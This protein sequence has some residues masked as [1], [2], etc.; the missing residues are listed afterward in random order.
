MMWLALRA[1]SAR[2]WRTELMEKAGPVK[3]WTLWALAAL[4]AA[5]ILLEL[6]QHRPWHIAILGV[7]LIHLAI[8]AVMYWRQSRQSEDRPMISLVLL[9]AEPRYLDERALGKLVEKA[10]GVAMDDSRDALHFVAGHSPA[11]M[12]R[13]NGRTFMVNNLN[14]PYFDEPQKAAE[15]MRELRLR[16]IVAEHMAWLSVHL[17]ASDNNDSPAQS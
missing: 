11:L 6:F 9:L 10:W 14:V 4:V 17:L 5:L 12:I 8:V 15:E 16:K 3:L 7:T 13:A 1:R 2:H